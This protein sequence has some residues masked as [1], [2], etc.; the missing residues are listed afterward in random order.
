MEYYASKGIS[1][2]RHLV[3]LNFTSSNLLVRGNCIQESG[4]LG[5]LQ[6]WLTLTVGI[7]DATLLHSSHVDLTS[8]F[9]R[10]N[11]SLRFR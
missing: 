2:H 6:D 7:I 1:K 8:L 11:P 4:D 10:H 5:S 3:Y 9:N